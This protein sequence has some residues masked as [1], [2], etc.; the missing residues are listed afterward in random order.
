MVR[1]W[2]RSLVLLSNTRKASSSSGGSKG[3]KGTRASTHAT[4]FASKGNSTVTTPSGAPP[5]KPSAA[6]MHAAN[7]NNTAFPGAIP[8]SPGYDNG[9]GGGYNR[10]RH[11]VFAPTQSRSASSIGSTSNTNAGAGVLSDGSIRP[12]GSS[13]RSSSSSSSSN[14][15]SGESAVLGTGS[16]ST[17]TRGSGSSMGE[18]VVVSGGSGGSSISSGGSRKEIMNPWALDMMLKALVKLRARPQEQWSRWVWRCC[19]AKSSRHKEKG[20]IGT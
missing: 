9:G 3:N 18:G 19:F 8:A 20:R 17:G 11:T 14:L 15:S 10:D 7:V 1:F 5:P 13:V 4:A 16:N 6:P 2:W 12:L